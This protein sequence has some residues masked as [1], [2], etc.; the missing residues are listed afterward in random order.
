[1]CKIRCAMYL[2]KWPWKRNSHGF[3]LGC[4]YVGLLV[5]LAMMVDLYENFG[6]KWLAEKRLSIF[7]NISVIR[8]SAATRSVGNKIGL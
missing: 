8:V 3:V 2:G 4:F 5:G 7:M 1:M 6:D